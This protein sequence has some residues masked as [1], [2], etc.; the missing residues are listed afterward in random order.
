MNLWLK[1]SL[2]FLVCQ[3]TSEPVIKFFD[4]LQNR[5]VMSEPVSETFFEYP[6]VE[7]TYEPVD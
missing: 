1:F 6:N 4:F 2:C 5:Q 7:V 3:V